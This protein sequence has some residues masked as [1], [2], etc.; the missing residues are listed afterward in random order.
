ME[1]APAFRA[2][3]LLGR[4]YEGMGNRAAAA[5]E[6]QASLSLASG[7]APARTALDQMQ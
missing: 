5:A 6:Y 7:F 2:H 1:D 3:Y 4:V